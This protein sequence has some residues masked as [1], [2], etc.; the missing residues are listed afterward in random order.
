MIQ[1]I[2]LIDTLFDAKSVSFCVLEEQFI[3]KN[4]IFVPTFDTKVTE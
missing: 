3:M 2:C 4:Q 1:N